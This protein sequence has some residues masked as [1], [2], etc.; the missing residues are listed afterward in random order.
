MITFKSI[1]FLAAGWQNGAD[2]TTVFP[3]RSLYGSSSA[4]RLPQQNSSDDGGK[5]SV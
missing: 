4:D 5:L 2:L 1:D 3:M